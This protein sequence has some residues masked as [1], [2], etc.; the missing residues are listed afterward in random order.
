MVVNI[1]PCASVYD[2]TL[3]AL[4]FSSIATQVNHTYTLL[5]VSTNK[6]K[7]RIGTKILHVS[8]QLVH[9]PST[10]SRV[11][12]I[13]SLLRE[14]AQDGNESSVLEEEDE[15]DDEDT[16]LLNTEV[17][18]ASSVNVWKCF[19]KDRHS[20]SVVKQLP[21]LYFRLCCTPSVS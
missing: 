3:H 19:Y 7:H 9:G 4:K 5:L 1:S 16:S 14:P 2:E 15:N 10:M 8:F 11:A 13:L 12:Y 18:S 6:Q 20:Y 21:L 17:I